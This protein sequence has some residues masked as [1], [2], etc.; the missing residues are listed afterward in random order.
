MRPAGRIGIKT[1]DIFVDTYQRRRPF[2]RSARSSF[3]PDVLFLFLPL[4]SF[5]RIRLVLI[6]SLVIGDVTISRVICSSIVLH[7]G[8][9]SLRFIP[10]TDREVDDE[11]QC[12]SRGSV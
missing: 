3:L 7:C 2:R 5:R 4:C 11:D 6:D 12:W 9:G 10:C 8:I 1:D